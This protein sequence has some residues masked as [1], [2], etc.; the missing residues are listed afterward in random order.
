MAWLHLRLE[1]GV[2]GSKA[3]GGREPLAREPL[4]DLALTRPRPLM[5]LIPRRHQLRQAMLAYNTLVI[6]ML[7]LSFSCGIAALV[8]AA[9][10]MSIRD[11]NA[12]PT[13][14]LAPDMAAMDKTFRCI[15]KECCTFNTEPPKSLPC[16]GG[17]SDVSPAACIA[18]NTLN[19]VVIH[20]LCFPGGGKPVNTTD[21]D[22]NVFVDALAGIVHSTAQPVGMFSLWG[23][24]AMV[25]CLAA[26]LYVMRVSRAEQNSI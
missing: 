3:G 9:K 6:L 14:Y 4:A 25:A 12:D 18:I 8:Y 19:P 16:P 22:E 11:H 13:V 10:V 15:Y 21:A 20:G 17:I 23:S 26:M 24:A 5:L 7:F 1:A 2:V